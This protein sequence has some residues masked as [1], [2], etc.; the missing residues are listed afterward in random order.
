MLWVMPFVAQLCRASKNCQTWK[1]ASQWAPG[2]KHSQDSRGVWM[3]Y[4]GVEAGSSIRKDYIEVDTTKADY[5]RPVQRRSCM[6][7]FVHT[8][9]RSRMWTAGRPNKA[10]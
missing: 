10:M 6:T 1:D 7:S 8:L 9:G 4:D 2:S 5:S 3:G